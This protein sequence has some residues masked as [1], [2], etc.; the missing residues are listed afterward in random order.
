MTPTCENP[1][2]LPWGQRKGQENQSEP[3]YGNEQE[4]QS[5][6]DSAEKEKDAK[7][8]VEDRTSANEL[9]KREQPPPRPVEREKDA[10]ISE[11]SREK[12]DSLK[13][14]SAHTAGEDS[15]ALLFTSGK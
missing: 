9:Q 12:S 6:S 14:M 15:I 8:S 5:P 13:N 2:A 10:C 3:S 7:G 11:K 1:A 4:S